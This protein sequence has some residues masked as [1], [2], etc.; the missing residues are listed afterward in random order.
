MKANKPTSPKARLNAAA[1]RLLQVLRHALN[2]NDA[3]ISGF[4]D[5]T[6][7]MDMLEARREMLSAAIRKATKS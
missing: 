3:D 4:D 5:I 2:W 7:N 6:P 1:P